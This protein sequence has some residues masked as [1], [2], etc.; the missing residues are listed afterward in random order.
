MSVLNIKKFIYALTAAYLGGAVATIMAFYIVINATRKKFPELDRF[1][2]VFE[3]AA[4]WW[5]FIILTFETNDSTTKLMGIAI[6]VVSLS[7]FS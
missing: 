7:A 2:T 1:D 6:V 3:I 5:T 4:Q